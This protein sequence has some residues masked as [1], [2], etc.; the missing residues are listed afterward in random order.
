MIE[1]LIKWLEEKMSTA[2]KGFNE[3]KNY[4]RYFFAGK[5]EAFREV[6]NWLKK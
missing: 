3:W 6:L 2:K 1:E 4:N 5:L